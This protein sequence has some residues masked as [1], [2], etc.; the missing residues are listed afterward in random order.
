MPSSP[1]SA[2]AS[3]TSREALAVAVVLAERH[4][5]RAV[6]EVEEPVA[7]AAVGDDVDALAEVRAVGRRRCAPAPSFSGVG[8]ARASASWRV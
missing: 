7:H 6:L 3:S 4:V 1:G 5:L 8:G 2:S